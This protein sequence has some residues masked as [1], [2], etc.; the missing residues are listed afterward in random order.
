MWKE[1]VRIYDNPEVHNNFSDLWYMALGIQRVIYV[2]YIG[3]E[4]HL[5]HV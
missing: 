5:I 2:S 3:R 4:N 1:R